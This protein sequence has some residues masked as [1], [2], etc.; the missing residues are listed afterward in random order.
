MKTPALLSIWFCLAFASLSSTNYRFDAQNYAS[1]DFIARDVAIIGGGCSG[2][3][4]AIN[5]RELGKS[6]LSIEQKFILGGHANN[7]IDPTTGVSV[8]HGVQAFSNSTSS[9]GSC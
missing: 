6:V 7:Y 5:L 1:D 4:G 8:D 2:T 9:K 3:Y